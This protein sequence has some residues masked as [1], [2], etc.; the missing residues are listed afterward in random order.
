M[1]NLTSAPTPE[2]ANVRPGKPVGL[3]VSGIRL[4]VGGPSIVSAGQCLVARSIEVPFCDGS[5]QPSGNDCQAML[6][7][8]VNSTQNPQ[9]P[10]TK[11]GHVRDA[12]HRDHGPRTHRASNVRTASSPSWRGH[13]FG[14]ARKCKYPLSSVDEGE[15]QHTL[16]RRKD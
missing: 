13:P 14:S 15:P 11:P 16:R 12:F 5:M 6:K 3:A 4:R 8:G 1:Q 9:L 10:Q 7:V 2:R